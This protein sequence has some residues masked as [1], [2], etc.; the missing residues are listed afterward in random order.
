M[1]PRSEKRERWTNR[2]IATALCAVLFGLL[3]L[4]MVL[5][6]KIPVHIVAP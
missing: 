4:G 2:L 5:T 6:A 1:K 3:L